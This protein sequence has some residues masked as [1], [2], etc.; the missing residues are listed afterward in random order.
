MGYEPFPKPLQANRPGRYSFSSANIYPV[1]KKQI[2]IQKQKGLL[3]LYS[4]Q[5][6]DKAKKFYNLSRQLNGA[7][8]ITRKANQ[9]Y[10]LKNL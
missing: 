10:P 5:K 7:D 9:T 2:K 8:K 3:I 1:E 6:L 4:P